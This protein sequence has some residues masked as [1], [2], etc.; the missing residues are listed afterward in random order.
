M[1][2]VWNQQVRQLVM[3]FSTILVF[4]AQPADVDLFTILANVDSIPTSDAHQTT[5]ADGTRYLNVIPKENPAMI[6]G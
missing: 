6:F 5:D 4:T 1:P 3:Y 2:F